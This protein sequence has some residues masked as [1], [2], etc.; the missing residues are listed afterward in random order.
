MRQ[1]CRITRLDCLR[2]Q[3]IYVYKIFFYVI[4]YGSPFVLYSYF[5]MN[6]RYIFSYSSFIVPICH[7]GFEKGDVL[8]C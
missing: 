6:V 2:E 7:N 8:V 5:S 4:L 3:R 1:K